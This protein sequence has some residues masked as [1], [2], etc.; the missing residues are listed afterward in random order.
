MRDRA[1]E[2]NQPDLAKIA[3]EVATLAAWIGEA[4]GNLTDGVA[5]ETATT[6]LLVENA[7][8]EVGRQ[9]FHMILLSA[10]TGLA[11]RSAAHAIASLRAASTEARVPIMVGGGVF[12]RVD[13]LWQAV[14]ADGCAKSAS[15]SVRLAR[16]LTGLGAV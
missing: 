5:M 10:S 7:V 3:A 1:A 15:D 13:G 8:D 4:P 11:V 2:L 14:G 9:Q 12:A 6:L 16:E